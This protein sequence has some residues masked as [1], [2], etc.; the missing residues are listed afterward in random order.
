MK[1]N[2]DACLSEVLAHEGGYVN[3][4]ADPGGETNMGISRRSYPREDIRGMTR[5]RAAQIYR[6]DF[7]HPV[8]GDDLPPGLDLVAFDAGVNSGVS[9]GAKWLQGALGVAQDGR[10]GPQTVGRAQGPIDGVA[11]IQA[12]CA[13]RMGFLRGLRSW[14]TFSRGWTRRVASVE[15]AAVAMHTRS[16]MAVREEETKARTAAT[17]QNTGAVAAGGGGA[18]VTGL[19][20]LPDPVTWGL[21]ALAAVVVLVLLSKARVN[22]DR[23][24][25]YERRKK[26]MI[27]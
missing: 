27:A 16:V 7:W 4:P 21:I 17:K 20:G 6:R 25:A 9:R 23:A 5:V 13:A 10:I 22:S 1:S 26:E 24:A 8:R 3:H 18:T 11:V 15:A 14:R 2:F 19:E 12:A